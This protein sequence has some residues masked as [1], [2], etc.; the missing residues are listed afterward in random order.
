MTDVS[1]TSLLG[2]AVVAL[3]APLI[4]R[5]APRLHIPAVVLEIGFGIVIG[6]SVLGW[7]HVDAAVGVLSLIGLAFLLFLAG[8][9]LDVDQ[10]RGR[11]I[12][13]A[14]RTWLVSVALA[15]LVAFGIRAAGLSETPLLL[16]ITLASTSLGPLVPVVNDAGEGP[17]EFGPLVI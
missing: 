11:L 8:L 4:V 13:L 7:A 1:M 14:G 15:L 5:L 16:A 3:G 17:S 9:E 12:R 10:L 6:P 2:V